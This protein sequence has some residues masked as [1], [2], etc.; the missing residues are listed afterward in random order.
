MAKSTF[1]RR[2]LCIVSSLS[3]L[4]FPWLTFPAFAFVLLRKDVVGQKAGCMRCHQSKQQFK[5]FQSKL[6]QAAGNKCSYPIP[7]P[8]GAINSLHCW[9]IIQTIAACPTTE[10]LRHGHLVLIKAAVYPL[11]PANAPTH[12]RRRR[13]RLGNRWFG[14]EVEVAT[15]RTWQRSRLST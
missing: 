1:L 14:G 12:E 13:Q 6:R 11:N 3:H 9:H 8:M 15:W 5:L 7:T 4:G 10:C 2:H